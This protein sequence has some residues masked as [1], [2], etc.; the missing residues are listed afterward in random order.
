MRGCC[1]LCSVA[2]V[3]CCGLTCAVTSAA[4][5]CQ[6]AT[7]VGWQVDAR[8]RAYCLRAAATQQ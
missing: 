7:G 8:T 1:C 2:A 6:G 5:V 3:L 4:V